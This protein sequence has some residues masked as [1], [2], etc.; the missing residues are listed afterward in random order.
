MTGPE[1][2]KRRENPEGERR[3]GLFWWFICIYDSYK[4]FQSINDSNVDVIVCFGDSP[5]INVFFLNARR[6]FCC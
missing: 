3:S 6:Q 5:L 1:A 2:C 4:N